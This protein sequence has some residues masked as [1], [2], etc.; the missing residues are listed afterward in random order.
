MYAR[1]CKPLA[2][3]ILMAITAPVLPYA[4]TSYAP[5]PGGDILLKW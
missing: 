1:S 3:L 4:V 2:A 5:C